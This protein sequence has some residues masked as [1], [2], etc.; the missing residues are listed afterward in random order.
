[1]AACGG[2]GTKSGGGGYAGTFAIQGAP[3]GGTYAQCTTSGDVGGVVTL[4]CTGL[5]SGCA[6]TDCTLVVVIPTHGSGTYSCSKG[7]ASVQITDPAL[8]DDGAGLHPGGASCPG[9]ASDS[10]TAAPQP[11]C[12]KNVDG[13]NTAIGDCTISVSSLTPNAYD[14]SAPFGHFSGSISA[15]LYS[16]DKITQDCNASMET[17]YT[18][19]GSPIAVTID[20]GW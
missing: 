5:A 12:P 9:A 18:P 16:G 3:H 20:G 2:T 13:C 15:T 1:M 17:Q 6:A 4:S 8:P 11:D 10:I 19:V 7:E 14:V